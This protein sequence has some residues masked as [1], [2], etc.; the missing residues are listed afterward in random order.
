M[1]EHNSKPKAKISTFSSKFSQP[2]Y[3]LYTKQH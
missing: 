2:K 1:K 3:G